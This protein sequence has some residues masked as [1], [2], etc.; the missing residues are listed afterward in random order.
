MTHADGEAIKAGLPAQAT[1]TLN[2]G[3]D[4]SVRWLIGEDDTNPQLFGALRDMWNPRCFGNPGKVSDAFEYV[5]DLNNDGGGVH[6][7]SGIP[8]HAYALLVDGGTFN[9]QTIQGIGLTK[10]AHIYFR[11]MDVYQVPSTDFARSR[12]RARAFGTSIFSDGI[13]RTCRPATPPVSA[14]RS[15]TSCRSRRRCKA[16][17][18]RTDPPCDFDRAA[19]RPESAVALPVGPSVPALHRH[20]R[21]PG[22]LGARLDGQPRAA[23]LRISPSATGT[24]RASCRIGGRQGVLRHGPGLHLQPVHL[25]GRDGGAAPRQPGNRIPAGVDSP[26]LTFVHWFAT[27]PGFDGGNVRISVN[28]GPWN[29]VANADFIYNGYTETPPHR[30]PGQ[31]QPPGRPARVRRRG[32]RFDRRNLGPFDRQPG[33]VRA[34]RRQDPDP[35]RRSATIPAAAGPAG[36]STTSSSTCH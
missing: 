20:L 2:V 22:D 25:Q 5:C 26:R 19:A 7:N 35:L 17:E 34:R 24:S 8:N 13:S 1:I 11:A 31:Q 15:T 4:D 6:T 9:G 18:M 12:R 29:L 28:G 23:R 3:T 36:T 16:V 30:G 27:E 10:A 14:S 21:D 33:A 32:R